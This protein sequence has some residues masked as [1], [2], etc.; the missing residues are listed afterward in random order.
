MIIGIEVS[1]LVVFPL[2]LFVLQPVFAKF[3]GADLTLDSCVG[4]QRGQSH[5]DAAI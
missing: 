5:K 4:K 1:G 2:D 3:Y